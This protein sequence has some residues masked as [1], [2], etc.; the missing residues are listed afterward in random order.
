[1]T[2]NQAMTDFDLTQNAHV[3]AVRQKFLRPAILEKN[4]AE[5]D[6][7]L[8]HIVTVR[9]DRL[10]EQIE[11]IDFALTAGAMD[12]AATY[13]GA[14]QLTFD[15]YNS[16]IAVDQYAALMRI[17][18]RLNRL[19]T[20][21]QLARLFAP[22]FANNPT[23]AV[24]ASRI[25]KRAN[26]TEEQIVAAVAIGRLSADAPERLAEAAFLLNT[27]GRASQVQEMLKELDIQ[28]TSDA[29]LLLQYGRAL[30]TYPTNPR[31]REALERAHQLNP[32]HPQIRVLLSQA[33]LRAGRTAQ[34]LEA[35]NLEPLT[36]D[37]EPE[38]VRSQ[39][40]QVF[41]AAGRHLDAADA[42]RT[43]VDA[44]PGHTGWKRAYVSALVLGGAEAEAEAWYQEELETRIA[45]GYASF[46]DGLAEIEGRLEDAPIP[47][48]RFDWAWQRLTALGCLP[49]DRAEWERRCRWVTLADHLTVD[50]LEARTAE[51]DQ[52]RQRMHG[53][54]EAAS[55]LAELGAGGRGIFLAAAHVGALFAGPLGL[56]TSD[57]KFRWV[58]STPSVS[59]LP[60]SEQLISTFS[61]NR[62]RLAKNLLR[63]VRNGEVVSV[64]LDGT[65]AAAARPVRFYGGTIMLSDFVPRVIHQSGALS[66]FPQVLW[67]GDQITVKLVDLPQPNQGEAQEAFIERWFGG[68]VETL[69]DVFRHHPDNLRLSGGFWT[70]VRL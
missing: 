42:Y 9:P 45:N 29:N 67:E 55:R 31:A 51:A 25:F 60:G 23:M 14:L 26:E 66:F 18:L 35:L 65:E 43:L 3:N 12:Q 56:A 46:A 47:A 30:M 32:S 16:D 57:L 5:V 2:E 22:D 28:A 40:A 63:A 39:A 10:Q 38:S 6:R 64:A 8:T 62:L 17:N 4:Y 59:T 24:L 69:A 68:F 61:Q 58:A 48:M 33:C 21:V 53:V 50:W 11:R 19:E 52:I 54:E 41:S 27:H 70:E 7:I 1:M 36:F 13:A 44:N 37:A 49:P 20:A 34:A 15:T